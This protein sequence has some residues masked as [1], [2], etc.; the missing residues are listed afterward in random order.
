MKQ[1]KYIPDGEN[2]LE[3]LMAAMDNLGSQNFDMLDEEGFEDKELAGA[4]NKMLRGILEQ[5]N[6][7]LMRINDA[8]IRVADNTSVKDLIEQ[9]KAQKKPIENMKQAS[10]YLR[11]HAQE[12]EA[13]QIELI[14]LSKQAESTLKP[15]MLQLK[16][17][18]NDVAYQQA[19]SDEQLY[20]TL[21]QVEEF[22]KLLKKI[23]QDLYHQEDIKSTFFD[24]FD[25]G[26][27]ELLSNY[28]EL[29]ENCFQNGYRLYR[30]NRDIDNARNDM[31]RTNS[32]V[33][34]ID[35]TK[36]FAV[37]HLTLTWRLYN[38]IIEYEHLK[39]TQLNNPDRCK[40]GLWCRAIE[41]ERVKKSQELKDAYEA[42]EKL[43]DHAVACYVAKE[44]S[45]IQTAM[46]EFETT[47]EMWKKYAES[48]ERLSEL[49]RQNNISEETEVWVFKQ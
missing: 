36:V 41:D 14:A 30:I 45:D 32:K 5:N 11:V 23:S 1:I 34:W 35:S 47:L 21:E 4:F 2:D 43:H 39:I 33:S 6:R 46:N 29:L 22:L 13:K 10:E 26:I 48:L 12:N 7:F 3:R 49:M 40:F 16:A 9:V 19:D 44:A 18:Q 28:D 24:A 20:D 25:E 15:L 31:Y 38:N 17:G 27:G 37:D 42:H 8:Q